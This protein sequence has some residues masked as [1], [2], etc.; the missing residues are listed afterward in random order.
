M[1]AGGSQRSARK[2]P[3]TKQRRERMAKA[4][5]Q[6]QDGMTYEQIAEAHGMSRTQAFR[7]VQ[8]ALHEIIREPAEALLQLELNRAEEQHL[9]L[10]AEIGRVSR[11]LNSGTRNGHTDLKAVD[12]LRRLIET[13][14]RVA[15]TRHRLLGLDSGV[16]I[17]ATL[18]VQQ[19]I[20]SAFETIMSADVSEF[21]G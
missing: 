18:D 21:G 7:D 17:D 2:R 11:S 3:Y 5:K 6:R 1:P 14:D 15:R 20:A 4:L 10:N 16:H 12:T 8:D 9:R 13:Q 19:S